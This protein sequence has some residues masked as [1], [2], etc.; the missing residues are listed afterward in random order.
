MP[1]AKKSQNNSNY[2]VLKEITQH[3]ITPK[4]SLPTG[5]EQ[6]DSESMKQQISAKNLLQMVQ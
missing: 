5:F 6:E 3:L 1:E 4:L 2:D